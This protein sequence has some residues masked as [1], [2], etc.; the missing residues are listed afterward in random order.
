[1][2]VG[3]GIEWIECKIQQ[4]VILYAWSFL[5]KFWLFLQ[6]MNNCCILNCP[7][8]VP[9]TQSVSQGL[10][11]LSFRYFNNAEVHYSKLKIVFAFDN[12]WALMLAIPNPQ[13][14]WYSMSDD[15]HLKL[16]QN[17]GPNIF[18][19]SNICQMICNT[20]YIVHKRLSVIRFK[21]C[22]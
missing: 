15:Q 8:A 9:P 2:V 19:D 3:E 11:C 10:A 1:M 7:T 6:F 17:T 16:G 5:V 18:T 21:L 13:L 12:Q 4:K 22:I 14:D 20:E